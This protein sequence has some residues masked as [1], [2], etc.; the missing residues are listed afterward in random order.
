MDARECFLAHHGILGQKWGHKNGPPYPLGA[1]DHSAAEKKAGWRKS[2]AA[3]RPSVADR[4]KYGYRRL[5]R[6][7]RRESMEEEDLREISKYYNFDE[8]KDELLKLQK[9][10]ERTTNQTYEYYDKYVNN[11][12]HKMDPN[13]PKLRDY[14]KKNMKDKELAELMLMELDDGGTVKNTLYTSGLED[15]YYWERLRKEHPGFLEEDA[16]IRD[17]YHNNIRDLAR[18]MVEEKGKAPHIGQIQKD[19]QVELND[20][21]DPSVTRYD[22]KDVLVDVVQMTL[23]DYMKDLSEKDSKNSK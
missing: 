8:H 18:D 4:I 15:R 2:L 16:K 9:D 10:Y 20:N 21:N 14:I 13:D 23:Y 6:D 19:L 12:L 22:K 3:A 17:A 1:S 5:K 7:L 11:E